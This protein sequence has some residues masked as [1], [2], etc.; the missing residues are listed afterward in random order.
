MTSGI[1][2]FQSLIAIIGNIVDR[3]WVLR[4]TGLAVEI[5]HCCSGPT[6]EPLVNHHVLRK[7]QYAIQQDIISIGQRTVRVPS[8]DGCGQVLRRLV[9]PHKS[10]EPTAT[11]CSTPS[12]R[13]RTAH[14]FALKSKSLPSDFGGPLRLLLKNILTVSALTHAG[15][16]SLVGI[17]PDQAV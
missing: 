5:M 11:E 16:I 4:I 6:V 3:I 2:R 15:A 8:S 17:F 9:D 13:G 10:S 14:G 7:C 1:G 12:C